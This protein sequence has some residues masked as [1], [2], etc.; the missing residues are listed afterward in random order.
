[1]QVVRVYTGDDD[2]AHF[3]EL[4]LPYEKLAQDEVTGM[5]SASG[6]QFRSSPPGDFAD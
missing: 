2:E 1:M 5:R 4:E 3:E 6:V